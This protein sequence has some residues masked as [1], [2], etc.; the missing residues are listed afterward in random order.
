MNVLAFLPV[1]YALYVLGDVEGL[2]ARLIYTFGLVPSH[3]LAGR[4]LHT[5][6]TSMFMHA[7]LVHILGNMVYLHIFGDNVED[8][9]GRPLYLLL[10][11]FWGLA[12][13]FTHILICLITGSGLDVPLVGA[14]GAISGVLG[15]YVVFFPRAQILT[16]GAYRIV[17]I[18]AIYYIG[19]WFFYQLLCGMAVLAV[20][21]AVEVAYWAHIGG[22]LAGVLV[23]LILKERARSE[24]LLAG[25]EV[26]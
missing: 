8:V 22:F 17:R 4:D 7:N 20:G 12:A 19:F 18:R 24:A 21:V 1:F 11:L 6:I 5:L 13:V 26:W 25:W 16:Y 15:A 23:G 14:S 3:L 10:Y 2:Y 9:L